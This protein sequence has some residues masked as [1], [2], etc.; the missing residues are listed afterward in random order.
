MGVTCAE[1]AVF[2]T[3]VDYAFSGIPAEANVVALTIT[4]VFVLGGMMTIPLLAKNL[5]MSDWSDGYHAL[6]TADF[7]TEVKAVEQID[8]LEGLGLTA[9]EREVF[10]LLMRGLL[11]KQIAVHLR[12][13]YST[14][15]FH[16]NNLYRKLDVR[17]RSEMAAK[18]H[19][20]ADDE[21]QAPLVT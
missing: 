14:V 17:G 12:V 9:R 6:D 3:G 8:R 15:N 18:Y 11:L 10:I 13:S 19:E 5:F 20:Y 2:E 16:T 1:Y 7:A 4:A 21:G